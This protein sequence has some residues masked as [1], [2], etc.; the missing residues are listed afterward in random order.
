MK[1]PG[2]LHIQ[3][4]QLPIKGTI[5]IFGDPNNKDADDAKS[6]SRIYNLPIALSSR[7]VAAQ[8]KIRNFSECAFRQARSALAN[9]LHQHSLERVLKNDCSCPKHVFKKKASLWIL[10]NKI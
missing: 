4:D 8:L 3:L 10:W 7:D 5:S 2:D 1:S 9:S 6:H